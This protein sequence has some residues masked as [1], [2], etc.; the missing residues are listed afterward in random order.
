M[1]E[2]LQDAQTLTLCSDDRVVQNSGEDLQT[3]G[4]GCLGDAVSGGDD[5]VVVQDG[6]GANVAGLGEEG[7]LDQAD[8]RELA[9]Q[10]VHTANNPARGPRGESGGRTHGNSQEGNQSE[11]HGAQ[12]N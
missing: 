7:P 5:V 1:N 8:L 9:G 4:G 3:T 12:L 10:C 11:F 2:G 6:T